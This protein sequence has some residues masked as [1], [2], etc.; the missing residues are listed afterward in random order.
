[1]VESIGLMDYTQPQPPAIEVEKVSVSIAGVAVLDDVSF[2]INHGSMV[3]LV[4]PNG[5][6]KSTLFRTI[7]GLI[8]VD[9][10]RIRVHGAGFSEVA[11]ELSYIPQYEDVNWSFPI[12][13][14]SVVK[15]G[16]QRKIGFFKRATK[17][18]KEMCEYSL[19]K[20]RLYSRKD[21]LMS[22]LS[23]G[24]KQRIFVAR[25]LAQEAHTLLLDEAFSGVDVGTQDE[26]MDML[27]TLTDDGKT[28]FISTH[29]INNMANKFDLVCC[30]NRHVC[31]FGPPAQ[32]FTPAILEELYGSHAQ[33]ILSAR[34][35]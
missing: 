32:A 16:T 28:I 1:M 9:T 11:G 14:W 30:L 35:E 19:H 26:L 7:L 10:G 23:G 17:I 3:G 18:D 8:P 31:C 33:V 25:A 2:T 24:Q 21:S 29:D 34:S 15:L 22:E 6:G 12:S 27:K 5:A 13:A 4:G 20:E